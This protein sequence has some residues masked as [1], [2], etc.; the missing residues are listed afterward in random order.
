MKKNKRFTLKPTQ[1]DHFYMHWIFALQ[2]LSVRIDWVHI[3]IIHIDRLEAMKYEDDDDDGHNADD[4]DSLLGKP[5]IT[6]LFSHHFNEVLRLTF[7]SILQLFSSI[8]VRFH[9]NV[10]W[11]FN[12]R[13]FF[14]IFNLYIILTFKMRAYTT[15]QPQTF[16]FLWLF[17]SKRKSI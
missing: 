2:H 17:R 8:S 11:Y 10:M 5:S 6:L 15:Q 14:C 4:N 16:Y 7:F 3:S 1:S 9:S 13:F 12:F